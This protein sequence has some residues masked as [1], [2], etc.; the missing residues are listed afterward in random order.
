M[1]ALFDWSLLWLLWAGLAGFWFLQRK[2]YA[3]RNYGSSRPC[4]DDL[5]IFAVVAVV[6]TLSSGWLPSAIFTGSLLVVAGLLLWAD[7]VLLHLYGFEVNFSNIRI[8]LQGVESFSGD[9]GALVRFVRA[10]SWILAA[11]VLVLLLAALMMAWRISPTLVPWLV[12][13]TLVVVLTGAFKVKVRWYTALAYV[14]L[15]VGLRILL[16]LLPAVPATVL[17]PLFLVGVSLLLGGR[18]LGLRGARFWQAR[19]PLRH[20]LVGERLQ[21]DPEVEL[22]AKDKALIAPARKPMQASAFHGSCRAANV[23]LVTLESVSRQHVESYVPGKARMSFFEELRRHGVFSHAHYATCPNTNRAV[24]HLYQSD[25][26]DSG[27]PFVSALRAAGYATGYMMISRTRYFRLADILAQ[28][29]FE[30]V[31]DQDSLGLDPERGDYGFVDHVDTML[32]AFGDRPFFLHLKNEQTHS[33]YHVVD[34]QGFSRFDATTREG[35]YLNA[36]EEADRVIRE[37]VA[38]VAERRSLDNTVII[39]TGDHG[40]SFGEFGYVA[41]SS[42]TIQQQVTVPFVLAHPALP[43]REVLLSTHFDV[44]PTVMDLLGI[45]VEQ[46]VLGQNLLR[47]R[48]PLPLLL[49]SQTRKGNAPS[50]VALLRE[51]DKIMIDSLYG[52]RYALDHE[53]R[54][55]R[56]LNNREESY[57]RTLLYRMLES[58]GLLSNSAFSPRPQTRPD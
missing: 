31:W 12:A 3:L 7:V 22:S 34:R 24:Q 39:V 16:P 30:H 10:R 49:Y 13:A 18:L 33:P 58:R 44:M 15:L 1:T 45:T 21:F 20:F 14:T 48:E 40:Q 55:L 26:P 38:A 9:A 51:K 29:G 56:P 54:I 5:L 28:V 57:Y 32:S 52:F 11:P 53:D 6:L 25:Y 2:I 43:A 42:S 50:S 36:V 47:S 19:S 23:I 37:F 4:A 17:A 27:Y 41:H 46:P 8:F 35:K